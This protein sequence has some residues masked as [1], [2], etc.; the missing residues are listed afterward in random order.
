MKFGEEFF[1][2]DIKSVFES[3]LE[4]RENCGNMPFPEVVFSEKVSEQ[5]ELYRP[6]S[7]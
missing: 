5:F 3:E 4:T 7:F 1:D 6:E 2:I